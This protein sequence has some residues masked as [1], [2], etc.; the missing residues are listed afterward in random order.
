LERPAFTVRQILAAKAGKALQQHRSVLRIGPI[1]DLRPHEGVIEHRLVIERRGNIDDAAGQSHDGFSTVAAA[2]GRW[3]GRAD[4]AS[5]S[6]D[7]L[8][9]LPL[10][11]TVGLMPAAR[12]R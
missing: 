7:A 2:W 10:A 6:D 5:L 9:V 8:D 3:I 11:G 12:C 4:A 1:L